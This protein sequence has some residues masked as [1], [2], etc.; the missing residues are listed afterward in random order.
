MEHGSRNTTLFSLAR[1]LFRKGLNGVETF[2][3]L[4]AV[5]QNRCKPL[6]DDDELE[7]IVRSAA[8]YERGELSPSSSFKGSDS[9]DTSLPE[10]KMFK[11]MTPPAGPRPYIVDGVI[12]QGFAGAIYGDGGSAK[13]MLVMHMGQCVARGDD[14]LGFDT[15]KT[16]VLYLDFEL[17]EEEQSRRGGIVKSCGSASLITRPPSPRFSCFL[18]PVLR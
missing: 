3:A 1:S 15:V 12:F 11:D 2:S 7:N 13:S 4:Y 18:Q 16:N 9:D 10:V 8:K 6:L 17:D 5:N 14:W